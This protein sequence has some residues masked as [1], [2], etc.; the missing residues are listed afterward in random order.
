MMVGYTDEKYANE[1]ETKFL[2]DI[3]IGQ[4]AW[5]G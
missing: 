4:F 5:L 3:F 2:D 1:D